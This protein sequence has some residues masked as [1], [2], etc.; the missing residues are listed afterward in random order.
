MAPTLMLM[1]ATAHKHAPMNIPLHQLLNKR[2]RMAPIPLSAVLKP[3]NPQP[4]HVPKLL[5]KALTSLP[6]RPLISGS[7]AHPTQK[8]SKEELNK[9]DNTSLWKDRI[10]IYEEQV[11]TV[12]F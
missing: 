5:L 11:V 12:G 10:G 7:N 4:K 8:I 2:I 3:S 6:E 9:K 1:E